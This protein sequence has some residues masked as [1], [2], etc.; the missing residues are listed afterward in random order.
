MKRVGHTDENKNAYKMF[1]LKIKGKR[2]FGT[3]RHGWQYSIKAH[4][5]NMLGLCEC[6][7]W[8][9]LA[10]TGSSGSVN[11][12]KIFGSLKMLGM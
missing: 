12:S 10:Q 7:K 5:K 3:P 9:R 8:I 1:A 4:I 6:V 2:S 11:K